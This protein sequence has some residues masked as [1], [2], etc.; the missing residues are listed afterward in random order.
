MGGGSPISGTYFLTLQGGQELTKGINVRA[1]FSLHRQN[2]SPILSPI[3][4]FLTLSSNDYTNMAKVKPGVPFQK[5]EYVQE[6]D[7]F[8]AQV[9]ALRATWKGLAVTFHQSRYDPHAPQSTFSQLGGDDSRFV[10][11]RYFATLSWAV[12]FGSWGSLLTYARFDHYSFARGTV[13]EANPLSTK[14]GERSLVKMAARDARFEIGAQFSSQI[15]STNAFTLSSIAGAEYEFLDI[16]RWHFP[17]VWETNKLPTPTFQN[18]HFGAFLQLQGSFF[19]KLH[20]TLGG[21]FDYDGVYGAVF[22]PRAAIILTPGAGFYTKLLYGNAF[23]AP[24]YHD[25]YYFRK[26]AFYGNRSLR[27]ESVH[28]FE[29]QVGWQRSRLLAVSVNGYLSLFRDLITYEPRAKTDTLEEANYFP[30]TQLPDGSVDFKQKDN[31]SALTTFGAELE[32]RMYIVRGLSVLAS[33]GVFFGHSGALGAAEGPLYYSPQWQANLTASYRFQVARLE[34]IVALGA[35]IMGPKA[36]PAKAFTP[37]N[38]RFGV[39][40]PSGQRLGVP[41][42][43]GNLDETKDGTPYDPT[44]ETP[45]SVRTFLNFQVNKILGHFDIVLRLTNLLNRDNYDADDLLLYPQETFNAMLWL[46][47][48][49]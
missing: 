41:F 33:G 9:F 22:T 14:A 10:T 44:L 37:L 15:I 1:S 25:L 39:A 34:M 20:L 47:A 17:E 11:D 12:P 5:Y 32:L 19:Q 26:N 30:P 8:F 13:Y 21:R 23:K 7:E 31:T 29:V 2:R 6:G 3:K 45:I 18:H 24:S 40:D 42:W 35:Q 38:S 46:R 16:V 4:E 27:P 43:T 36:L 48:H 49:Y 28:T